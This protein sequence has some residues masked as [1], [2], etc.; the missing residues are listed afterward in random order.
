VPALYQVGRLVA[1]TNSVRRVGLPNSAELKEDVAGQRT[2]GIGI[3]VEPLPT[4]QTPFSYYDWNPN[5]S[6]SDLWGWSDYIYRVRAFNIDTGTVT[7]ADYPQGVLGDV[8]PEPYG[9]AS[10]IAYDGD[11]PSPDLI[12]VITAERY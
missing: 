1:L 12:E 9:S 5:T 11:A 10:G 6:Q 2:S 3:I 7:E 4:V 8:P